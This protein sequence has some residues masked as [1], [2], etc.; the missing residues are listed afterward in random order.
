V[1]IPRC[2]RERERDAETRAM[3]AMCRHVVTTPEMD[4][5]GETTATRVG[6]ARGVVVACERAIARVGVG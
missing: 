5:R 4:S 2:E 1:V 6:R 3:R